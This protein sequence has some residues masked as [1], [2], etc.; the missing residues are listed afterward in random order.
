MATMD[1]HADVQDYYGKQLQHSNDLKTDACCS[2]ASIPLFIRNIISQI[3]PNVVARYY[4]CG[5]VFPPKL[6]GCRVLDLG[7]GSGRDVFILSSLVGAQGSVVGVDMTK[8]QLDVAQ[9]YIIYHTKQFGFDSPNVDFRLGRIEHLIDEVA[10]E[11]DSLLGILLRIPTLS[12]ILL[13]RKKCFPSGLYLHFSTFSFQYY[14]PQDPSIMSCTPGGEFYF[15]DVYAD[16]PIAEELRRNKILWGECLSGAVCESDLIT[17][18]LDIGFTRPI[19]IT[20]QPIGVE[21]K[22]LLGDIKFASCTYRMFKNSSTKS[23]SSSTLSSC[24]ADALVAYEVSMTHYE[25]EFQF[26]Q[27]TIF[28]LHGKPERVSAELAH[29][30]II[31]RYADNFKFSSVDD[32]KHILDSGNQASTSQ[33]STYSALPSCCRNKACQ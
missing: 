22:E 17:G 6:N 28:K 14:R 29:M 11:V 31:S 15:S 2:K 5:L 20:K 32:G 12:N 8:E 16:R 18:A 4:G 23:G 26:D 30:T 9:E 10:L 3:H 24:V 25:D 33:T 19:L 13:L 21:N 7:C 1:V 27:T